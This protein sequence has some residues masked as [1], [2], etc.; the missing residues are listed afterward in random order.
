M[1]RLTAWDCIGR[2]PPTHHVRRAGGRVLYV[3]GRDDLPFKETTRAWEF[4]R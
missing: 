2:V 3:R 1:T 4:D